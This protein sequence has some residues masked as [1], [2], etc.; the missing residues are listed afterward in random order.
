M[1]VDMRAFRI[2]NLGH[3]WLLLTRWPTS[4][5]AIPKT[6]ARQESGA[7][8]SQGSSVRSRTALLCSFG[9]SLAERGIRTLR[10]AKK[11]IFMFRASSFTIL[12]CLRSLLESHHG[13]FSVIVAISATA[14]I[15]AM[16]MGTEVAYWYL[17]QR[18]MHNAADSAAIAAATNAGANYATEAKA[19]AALY[20]FT[21]G[22]GN[23]TVTATNPATATGC[24]SH[25]YVVTV[26]DDVPLFLSGAV[27]Y[28]G[29]ITVNGSK[30]TQL[31]ASAVA[32]FQGA[33]P[34]C[35]L[36]LASSGAEGIHTN[37]APTADLRN[38]NV[39]SDTTST[40]NGHDLNAAVGDAVGT[41]NGCGIVQNSNVSAVADPYSGLASNIPSNTCGSYPQEPASN[42]WSGSQSWSGNKIICGDLRLTGNTTIT[43]TGASVLVI[44]NGQLDTNGY[45]L[46]TASGSELTIVFTGTNSSSYTYAPTGGGTLD[47]QA[48]TSGPWSG[49]AIYQDPNLTTGVDI[50]A[51]GNSPTWNITGLVYLPHSSVTF[52]GAVNKSSNGATCF[53]MVVDNILI[54]GTADIFANDTQCGAAGL[55]QPKGGHRGQLVN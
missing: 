45:T 19:V 37:G 15:G 47:S 28:V 55:T 41:N 24:T 18:A 52:S 44:E 50:S 2:G 14:L 38:C 5:S 25:C 12:Q 16:G 17:H 36:A 27:G 6:T 33:Y 23:I 13:A 20:G 48:P 7:I 31:T 9:H 26:S 1:D 29:T 53:T 42:Q 46:S 35:I 11:E 22:S 34:Y 43:G 32:N 21:N 40:C 4:P 3:P 51:A 8:G 54:N 30:Q 10:G 39:M 49:V